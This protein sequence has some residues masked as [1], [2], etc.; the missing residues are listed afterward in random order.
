MIGIAIF[1]LAQAGPAVAPTYARTT[2][3]S[4]TTPEAVVTCDMVS[5]EDEQFEIH[6]RQTGGR[7][8]LRSAVQQGAEGFGSTPITTTVT[9]DT[10]GRYEG[11]TLETASAVARGWP[12]LK[13]TLP[14]AGEP[15]RTQ[16]ESEATT[17]TG[18][19]SLNIQPRWPLGE[20]W[21]NGF[22]LVHEAPQQ[23]LN[24]EEAVEF[25]SQ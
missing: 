18:R 20:I 12:G 10:S 24:D 5:I 11:L 25:F 4:L 16:F 9:R 19:I 22:C 1:L 7:G 21:A 6:F 23:P 15:F 3:A 13:R 14:V 2:P 8:Y 17:V